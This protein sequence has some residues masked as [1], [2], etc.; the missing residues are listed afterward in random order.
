M[1]R[2]PGSAKSI[3]QG[4]ASTMQLTDA[5]LEKLARIRVKSAAASF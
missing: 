4:A 1:M 5:I 2:I 3:A